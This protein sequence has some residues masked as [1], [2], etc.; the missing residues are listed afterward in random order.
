MFLRWVIC[1]HDLNFRATIQ[2]CVCNRYWNASLLRQEQKIK[3]VRIK[4]ILRSTSVKEQYWFYSV[5]IISVTHL[6]ASRRTHRHICPPTQAF[7]GP[8]AT[9]CWWWLI[10]FGYDKQGNRSVPWAVCLS[11]QTASG[12][13]RQ[14]GSKLPLLLLLSSGRRFKGFGFIFGSISPPLSPSALSVFLPVYR[15]YHKDGQT[16]SH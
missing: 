13:E 7:T 14:H 2:R 12:V 11:S 10:L 1:W 9:H 8:T 15:H 5:M 6:C 4:H 3:S 16:V